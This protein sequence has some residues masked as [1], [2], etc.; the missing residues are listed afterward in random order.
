M[1]TLVGFAELEL[2]INVLQHI[3]KFLAINSSNNFFWPF[4]SLLS[5]RIPTSHL[6]TLFRFF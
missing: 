2:Y 6:G 3:Y 5:S 4:S 1:V